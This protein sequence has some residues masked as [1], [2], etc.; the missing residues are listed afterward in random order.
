VRIY[1]LNPPHFPR[2]GAEMAGH[3]MGRYV[4]FIQSGFS[5][6]YFVH[7]NSEK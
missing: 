7:L 3:G 1:L 4:V 5:W 6:T 2:R